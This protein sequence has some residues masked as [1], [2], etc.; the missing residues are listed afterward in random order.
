MLNI[1]YLSILFLINIIK[2]YNIYILIAIVIIVCISIT[3]L[4]LHYF[5]NIDTK[6]KYTYNIYISIMNVIKISNIYTK[7]IYTVLYS[8][9]ITQIPLILYYDEQYYKQKKFIK[10]FTNNKFNIY[11]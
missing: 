7:Q 10:K 8:N 9:I 11:I 1:I 6:I 3:M 2:I 4:F 5:I